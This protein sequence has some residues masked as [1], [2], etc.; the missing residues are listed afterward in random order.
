M[1]KITFLLVFISIFGYAQT[2]I[3][4]ANRQM[5]VTDCLS[6]NPVD[7]MCS[8]SEYGAMPNWDVSSVTN[9]GAMFE[10]ASSF[11]ADISNW[12]VSSV[13]NMSNMF[14]NASSFN[15]DVSNWDISS[16][17]DMKVMFAYASSF[18]Q[19]LN[20]WET[21]SV[22]N[23]YA[24]FAYASSFNGDI[25]NWDVSSVNNMS[26]MFSYAS[27]FN[28]DVSNWDVSR[29]TNMNT[30]FTN[31]SS[32]N[33]PLNDW[34]VSSV[35]EMSVMLGNSA[36]STENYDALLNGWSQQNIQSNVTLGAQFLSY[37]NGEDARQSLIDNHN[38]TISDDG[39]DCSTAG[40]DDQKQLDISIYPNP[41]VDK[42][43]IQ[44]L[45]DATKI[46]VYDILG[47]LVLSKTILSEIDVTNLQ[48]GIYTIK[49]IDEQK[50][51]VQK[52]IKN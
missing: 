37:C 42:L 29:I 44:G 3:T 16:V 7:G 6:T 47:K 23:M 14:A 5:A 15:R 21:S 4:D 10:Y 51:T 45:S 25:S 33:Q 2:A 52:F 35:T 17:T 36:L 46:S 9:M 43:F 19:S 30:M 27:S 22:T 48:R 34:D 1:K 50:E 32:F 24:M 40:V 18:N 39:L 38:W 11:N 13:T 41:V 12:D 49:I 31:A 28:G 20:D 8:D 26:N